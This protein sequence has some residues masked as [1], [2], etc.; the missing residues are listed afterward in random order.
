MN[1]N[2]F[3]IPNLVIVLCNPKYEQITKHLYM[4]KKTNRMTVSEHYFKGKE[5]ESLKKS[6]N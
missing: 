5:K 2:P 3:I 4:I 1:P 6:S